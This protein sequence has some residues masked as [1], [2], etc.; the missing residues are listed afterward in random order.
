[1]AWR[2]K[3]W[4]LF[5]RIQEVLTGLRRYWP[6]TV[7]QVYYQLVQAQVIENNRN[8]YQKLCR[9]LSQARLDGM[10]PWDAIEDRSRTVLQDAAFSDKSQ[11]VQEELEYFLEGYRRDLLQSQPC[12]PEIWIEKDALAHIAYE[13][14]KPYC[15]PVLPARGFASTTYKN[16]CRKR[17]QRNACENQKTIILYF[18]DLDPSGW[19]MV[20]TMMR[21]LRVDMG[22]W[23]DVD[24]KRIAL[25]PEQVEEYDLPYDFD[26][27]KDGDSRTPKFRDMLDEMGFDPDMAVELDA[28]PPATLETLIQQAIEENLDLS[29]FEQ[30]K[31]QEEMELEELAEY[32]EKTL[33][34]VDSQDSGNNS[35]W[36]VP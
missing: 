27:M 6:L 2:K 23:G 32:R 31:D 11:F 18:G 25:N 4:E 15:V 13:V 9:L 14:A 17:V 19:E 1:M 5:E 7:R 16:E 10:V 20:P 34:T 22:L 30:E 35:T 3:T 24:E 28:L 36:D 26:A 29:L 8:E 12:R 21:T 33:E